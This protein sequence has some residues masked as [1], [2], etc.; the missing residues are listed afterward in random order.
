M[1]D[2]I[3]IQRSGSFPLESVFGPSEGI[4]VI[5]CS[6]DKD[7]TVLKEIFCGAEFSEQEFQKKWDQSKEDL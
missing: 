2:T 3:I 1:S 7:E 5:L 6:R 4:R